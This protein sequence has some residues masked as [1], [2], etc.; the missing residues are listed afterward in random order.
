[1]FLVEFHTLE[2]KL[3]RNEVQ[4]SP[5]YLTFGYPTSRFIRRAVSDEA[6]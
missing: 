5:D 4:W 3:L 2:E 6:E 1:M